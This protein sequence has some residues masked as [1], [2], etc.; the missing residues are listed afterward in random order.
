MSLVPLRTK[1]RK[2]GF[3]Y[4]GQHVAPASPSCLYLILE[5]CGVKSKINSTV[6]LRC[7]KNFLEVAHDTSPHS[8]EEEG[9]MEPL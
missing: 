5:A 8:L 6:G 7:P 4:L 3:P 9:Y 1:P 2:G